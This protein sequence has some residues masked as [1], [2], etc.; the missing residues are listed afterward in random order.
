[1]SREERWR[2][3][4]PENMAVLERVAEE[5]WDMLEMSSKEFGLETSGTI[6][7]DASEEDRDLT[8]R[9]V[10]ILLD[11]GIILPGP[12]CAGSRR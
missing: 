2:D 1:M 9:V 3:V 10:G 4:T 5:L 12:A 7:E 8:K 6:W 11:E